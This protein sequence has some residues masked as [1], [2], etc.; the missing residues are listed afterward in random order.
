MLATALCVAMGTQVAFAKMPIISREQWGANEALTLKKELTEK[1][2]EAIKNQ[3]ENLAKDDLNEKDSAKDSNS[4][5]NGANEVTKTVSTNKEGKEYLWPISYAKNVDFIV[6]HHTALDATGLDGKKAVQAVFN[7]HVLFRGWGDIGYNYLID[8]KGNV[9]E[10]R[11]GGSKAIG[12]HSLP[13]NKVSMGIALL[14]NYENNEVTA[15]MLNSLIKLIE[16]KSLLYKINP[17]GKTTYKEKKY[18]NVQGHYENDATACPGVYVIDILPELR[19]LV[20]YNQN[21]YKNQS[22]ATNSHMV[23]A[24]LSLVA[25]SSS[26][27]SP[28]PFKLIKKPEVVGVKPGKT[29]VVT[30]RVQNTSGTTWSTATY[31]E[32]TDTPSLPTKIGTVTSSTKN[33]ETANFTITLP[34]KL[35]SEF[36]MP[37]VRVVINGSQ[38]TNYTFPFPVLYENI[39]ATY[40]LISVTQPTRVLAPGEKFSGEIVI[41]NTGNIPWSKIGTNPLKLGTT[42]PEDHASELLDGATRL[43]TMKE[44]R[45]EPG[46]LATFTYSLTQPKETTR[47]GEYVETLKPVIEK[48][49]WL[50]GQPIVIASQQSINATPLRVRLT[51]S[52]GL[53]KSYTV[54]AQAGLTLVAKNGDILMRFAAGNAAIVER[55]AGTKYSVTNKATGTKVTVAVAPRFASLEKNGIVT[56]E[57][58]EKRPAWNPQINDNLFRGTVEFR[59]EQNGLYPI[60]ELPL[61]LYMAGLAEIPNDDQLEKAK[62][63]AIAARSYATF[64]R[65]SKEKFPGKP[66]HLDDDPDHTQKYLGAGFELRSQTALQA[67]QATKGMIIT[68]NGQKVLTPYFNQSDGKTRSAQAVWGWQNAPYLVS[69]PDTFCG[70]TVLKGHGVGLSGCGAT[71]LAR[72]GKTAEEILK[73]YY[74]GIEVRQL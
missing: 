6:V 62:A 53:Q 46:S 69:V 67:V 30:L 43:N 7:S 23:P 52:K 63:L 5:N 45:V 14:G 1:E 65:D 32:N 40:E 8:E 51:D 34:A 74:K 71:A 9:Y 56:I 72:Q 50:S 26:S 36:F 25:D 73:Y 4:K 16:E 28:R 24:S 38:K 12:G 18:N 44:T 33:G 58:F 2:R 55:G 15:P 37:N 35:Q 48:V 59:G 41:K 70:S 47:K 31:L 68:F 3:K 17:T 66:Y 13:L 20:A 42:G 60:N 39:R 64:Y 61:E 10:G 21:F 27:A 11:L 57:N 29:Q 22:V 49:R 54:S 19:T